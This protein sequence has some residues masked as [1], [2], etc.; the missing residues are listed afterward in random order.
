MSAGAARINTARWAG[1]LSLDVT[2]GAVMIPLNMHPTPT[3]RTLTLQAVVDDNMQNSNANSAL[4]PPVTMGFTLM[5]K[6]LPPLSL[7]NFTPQ[8]RTIYGLLNE[9]NPVRLVATL[10]APLG[11]WKHIAGDLRISTVGGGRRAGIVYIP[12]GIAPQTGS[13]RVLTMSAAL[14][15]FMVKGAVLN[16]LGFGLTV[17]YIGVTRLAAQ[18]EPRG[19]ANLVSPNV[20]RITAWTDNTEK[21]DVALLNSTRGGAGNYTYQKTGGALAFDSASRRIAIPKNTPPGRLTLA[22]GS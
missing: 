1:E 13:G 10:T 22:V 2:S 12:A 9:I 11:G 18:F 20:Y 6:E 4:T 17:N 5:Y 14:T 21:T 7:G 19:R 3:G 15:Q 16:S 8:T